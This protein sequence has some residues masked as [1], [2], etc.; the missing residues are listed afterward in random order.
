MNLKIKKEH[1][2]RVIGFNNSVRPLGDRN[3]LLV[4]AEMAV[5]SGNKNLLDLF[6]NV[7]TQK[8]ID[9]AKSQKFIAETANV[10]P[11]NEEQ[12]QSAD[13]E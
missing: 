11:R 2:D 8:Q 13:E 5:K 1:K 7:P 3:D 10:D 12:K 4:L 9:I 6:E